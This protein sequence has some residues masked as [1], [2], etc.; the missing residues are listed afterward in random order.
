MNNQPWKS[1]PIL[2]QLAFKNAN[3]SQFQGGQKM[4]TA[5]SNFGSPDLASKYSQIDAQTNIMN[6]TK[7]KSN[8][9]APN[10]S[11]GPSPIQERTQPHQIRTLA[12]SGVHSPAFTSGEG[13]N[14]TPSVL[15]AASSGLSTTS[16]IDPASLG[17]L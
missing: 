2:H 17:K 6:A 1:A 9:N 13:M 14:A 15:D 16:Q 8:F 5:P 10:I 11:K 12:R 3:I 7:L 4:P